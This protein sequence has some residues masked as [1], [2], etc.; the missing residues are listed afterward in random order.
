MVSEIQSLSLKLT[1]HEQK[2]G[3][4]AELIQFNLHCGSDHTFAANDLLCAIYSFQCEITCS[5]YE[6]SRQIYIFFSKTLATHKMSEACI[7]HWSVA[8]I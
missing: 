8:H 2:W 7:F 4:I 5:D 6:K 3:K 1:F